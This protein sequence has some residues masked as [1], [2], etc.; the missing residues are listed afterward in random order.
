MCEAM[1]KSNHHAH[2][3]FQTKTMR[4]VRKL[5]NTDP[6]IHE[7]FFVLPL[8]RHSLETQENSSERFI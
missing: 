7:G 3:D 2:K 5:Y 4:G 1:E 6:S 8:P